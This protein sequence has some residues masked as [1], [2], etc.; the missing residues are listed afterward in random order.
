M[1]I[2][3]SGLPTDARSRAQAAARSAGSASPGWWRDQ[4]D[5]PAHFPQAPGDGRPTLR[6]GLALSGGEGGGRSVAHRGQ[7]VRRD[8]QGRDVRG[9]AAGIDRLRSREPAVV[10]RPDRRGV[11]VGGCAVARGWPGQTGRRGGAGNRQLDSRT[12]ASGR[13]RTRSPGTSPPRRGCPDRCR[14]RARVHGDLA[15]LPRLGDAAS[16]QRYGPPCRPARRAL[17]PPDRADSTWPASQ[18]PGRR[19]RGGS[20]T[21][22]SALR[23]P[24]MGR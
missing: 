6:V 22:A 13:P 2:S 18:P 15:L 24:G 1:T 16:R 20:K 7:G 3:R 17:R 9:G 19:Y 23:A 14:A 11:L 5:R 10:D 12:A 8:V 4:G 21:A